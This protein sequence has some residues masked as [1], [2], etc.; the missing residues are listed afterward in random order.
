MNDEEHVVIA[1]SPNPPIVK[2][3]DGGFAIID[4]N[5]D[6]YRVRREDLLDLIGEI[7]ND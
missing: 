3:P 1:Y 2:L 5:G 4:V 7:P 6:Q